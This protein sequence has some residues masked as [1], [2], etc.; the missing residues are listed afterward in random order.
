MLPPPRKPPLHASLAEQLR[1]P[2]PAPAPMATVTVQAPAGTVVTI[3]VGSSA[4]A[5]SERPPT[6]G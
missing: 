5:V 2:D 6:A 4:E 1:A 3:V